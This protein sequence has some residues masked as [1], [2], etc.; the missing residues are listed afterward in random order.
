M[1]RRL[2]IVCLL[3]FTLIASNA[4]A[5][6]RIGVE[7]NGNLLN[8]SIRTMDYTAWNLP[9]LITKTTG[10]NAGSTLA[11]DYD[12]SHARIK[13]VSTLHG[14]TYY[15]GGYELVIPASS[16]AAQNQTEERTYVSSPEG[17]IGVITQ[18]TTANASG[19]PTTSTDTAA[20]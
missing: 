11:Y 14:T 6:S 7:P 12:Q 13:E 4:H 16:T 9:K 5:F 3:L 17:T 10:S 20:F 8:D 18:K 19:G 2:H 1:K 15:A